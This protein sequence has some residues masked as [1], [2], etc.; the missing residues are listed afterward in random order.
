VNLLYT[1]LK[2]LLLLFCALATLGWGACGVVG[3]TFSAQGADWDPLIII[4]ALGGFVLMV[5][6][7]W[8]TLKLFRSIFPS[9]D[10]RSERSS[11]PD[12]QAP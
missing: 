7:G 4:L 2:S 12:D 6:F 5:L 10:A 3:L 11:V 9:H 1:L 8:F